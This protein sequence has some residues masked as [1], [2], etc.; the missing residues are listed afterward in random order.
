MG[1]CSSSDS[2]SASGPSESKPSG[3]KSSGQKIKLSYFDARGRGETA[4]MCLAYSGCDWEDHR[5]PL[6]SAEWTALKPNTP[7]GT[8]PLLEVDDVQI[9]QSR[10]VARFCAIKAGLA[11]KS[12]VDRAIADG[13]VDAITDLNDKLFP[14]LTEGE[15]AMPAFVEL[16]ENVIPKLEAVV[17]E[18][19]GTFFTGKDMTWADLHFQQFVF[20]CLN[21]CETLLD[22]TP[23]LKNL[24]E[25]TTKNPK[26]AAWIEKRPETPF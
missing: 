12:D 6:G 22:D 24:Y 23:K 4:R 11:G 19:K 25:K 20:T 15:S 8:L 16:K 10:C 21:V 9:G 17:V 2:T 18:N 7:W 26:I 13:V 14:V 3:S 1:N 5:V